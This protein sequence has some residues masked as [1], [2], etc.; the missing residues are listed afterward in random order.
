MPNWNLIEEGFL[1]LTHQMQ[2]G[3]LASC[4]ARIK[5]WSLTG[6]L[7]RE[8]VS[9][10]LDEAILYTSL[11]ERENPTT[12]LA[13]LQQLL[14]DWRHSWLTI[15]VSDADILNISAKSAAWSDRLL[16]MSGLLQLVN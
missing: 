10:I 6:V 12:E 9:I 14:Q 15:S 5:A 11:L 1:K 2:L 3:E 7:N 8:V 4:L 13:Q 16:D